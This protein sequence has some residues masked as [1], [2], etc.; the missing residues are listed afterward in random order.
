MTGS[1]LGTRQEIRTLGPQC[2]TDLGETGR[3]DRLAPRLDELDVID[4]ALEPRAQSSLAEPFFFA[5]GRNLC[6]KG[7]LERRIPLHCSLFLVGLA[8]AGGTGATREVARTLQRNTLQRYYDDPEPL[9]RAAPAGAGNTGERL[10]TCTPG[11]WHMATRHSSGSERDRRREGGNLPR[12]HP[13]RRGAARSSG[14]HRQGPTASS[15]KQHGSPAIPV[16]RTRST[17]A[18]TTLYA[19]K[20]RASHAYTRA[21]SLADETSPRS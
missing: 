11:R 2:Q 21:R 14:V 9:A 16:G 10:T 1:L 19:N 3:R 17:T 13:S 15:P 8:L 6:S 20:P 12:T 5:S 7:Q 18:C 4:P